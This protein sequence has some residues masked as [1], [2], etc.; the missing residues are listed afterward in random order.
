MQMST[1]TKIEIKDKNTNIFNGIHPGMPMEVNS[2]D[3]RFD[4]L[5]NDLM[6]SDCYKVE[7]NDYNWRLGSM[8]QTLREFE[9]EIYCQNGNYEKASTLVL[10][11]RNDTGAHEMEKMVD[12]E[13]HSIGH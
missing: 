7:T 6:P 13:K 3:L 2:N 1:T 11:R 12:R 9:K 8:K 10:K 5:I 4:L